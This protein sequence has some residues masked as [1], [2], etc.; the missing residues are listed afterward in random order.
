MKKSKGDKVMN[1]KPLLEDVEMNY[2]YKVVKKLSE[3]VNSVV[4][5]VVNTHANKQRRL[6]MKLILN[7]FENEEKGR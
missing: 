2:P 5:Q 1:L 7:P 4:Y 3:G 6:A